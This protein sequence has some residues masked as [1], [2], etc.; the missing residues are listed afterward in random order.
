MSIDYA[1]SSIS[2]DSDVNAAKDQSWGGYAHKTTTGLST[3]DVEA[4]KYKLIFVQRDGDQYVYT[5][6]GTANPT[7]TYTGYIAKGASGAKGTGTPVAGTALEFDA[8]LLKAIVGNGWLTG[9]LTDFESAR[10]GAGE[11]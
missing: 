7:Y 9:S 2:P 5:F 8:V 1:I 6:N 3:A 11:W 10:N 4:G